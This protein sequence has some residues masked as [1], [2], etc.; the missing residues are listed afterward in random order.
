[1]AAA[2]LTVAVHLVFA[3]VYAYCFIWDFQHIDPKRL[4]LP[5]VWWSRF[6]WLTMIDLVVQQIYH[7]IAALVAYKKLP[8]SIFDFLATSIVFPLAA[9][10]VFLFWGLWIANPNLVADDAGRN[11]LL[12]NPMYNHAIHT[13]PLFAMIVDHVLWRHARACRF[14]ASAAIGVFTGC[15]IAWVVTF[16]HLFD[17]WAYPILA[18]LN[19]PLRG[20]FFAFA[21]GFILANYF[22]GDTFNSFLVAPKESVKQARASAAA[23]KAF[24][25]NK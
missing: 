11:F 10:V 15:Y 13:L 3:A 18:Q 24:G 5:N 9:N 17:R 4:L 21:G 19:L 22:L 20:V 12:A 7:L 6:V 1:M 14:K 8:R 16:H 2:Q 23:K 25:K